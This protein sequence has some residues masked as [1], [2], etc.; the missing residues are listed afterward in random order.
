MTY[1]CYSDRVTQRLTDVRLV[2]G[3]ELRPIQLRAQGPDDPV[4]SALIRNRSGFLLAYETDASLTSSGGLFRV[5]SLTGAGIGKGDLEALEIDRVG[6]FR[7]IDTVTFE[8]TQEPEKVDL[9]YT[10]KWLY[11]RSSLPKHLRDNGP[12]LFA[13]TSGLSGNQVARDQSK[14]DVGPVPEG[15]YILQ[16]SL[17]DAQRTLE[18]ANRLGDAAF[19]NTRQGV[20][21][22]PVGGN[23]P[24]SPSWG[25][26]RVRIEMVKGESFK[27]GGFYLH[28]SRKGYSHGCIEV[29][30]SS[31]HEDFFSSLSV[32]AQDPQ[33]KRQL[34]LRV[35]YA[36]PDQSTFGSTKR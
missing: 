10:G 18:S 35:R 19:S 15:L 24:V 17:D 26:F 21:C 33:R 36:F 30:S 25:T 2:V 6:N 9:I 1:F 5:F 12:H 32:Y 4:Q 23:G 27:R 20:Q 3:E 22:L 11:W 29:G 14:K 8:V 31:R 16:A 28:N 13:A 7:I 34:S